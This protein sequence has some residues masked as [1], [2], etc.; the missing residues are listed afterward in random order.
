MANLPKNFV[1]F[2]IMYDELD[3]NMDYDNIMA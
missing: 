1:C 3:P 2:I